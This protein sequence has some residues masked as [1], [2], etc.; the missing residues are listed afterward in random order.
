M[1]YNIILFDL[2]NTL[3]DFDANQAESLKMLFTEK[4]VELTD[5]IYKTYDGINRNLWV[6][7]ELGKISIDTLLNTR[8]AKTMTLYNREVDGEKWEIDYRKYLN[9]GSQLIDGVYD[10]LGELSKSHR[11]FA[12]TNGVNE[13]QVSRLKL[14]GIYDFFEDVFISEEVGA[15]KPSVKFFDYAFSHICDFKKE[16]SLMVG[17]TLTSDIK[18]GLDSGI[19]TCWYN[20]YGLQPSE[21]IKS[22]YTIKELSE[23]KEILGM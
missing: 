2:D 22:T 19:D 18:G 12:A 4:G 8:F 3:F 17:D 14:S 20:P 1:S 9:R 16:E 6:E 7:Y 11:L 5:E 15:Q 13:T 10:L 23:L 21:L